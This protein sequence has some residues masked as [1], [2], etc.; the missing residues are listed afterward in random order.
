M[1]ENKPSAH[2]E[3]ARI[4]QPYNVEV[5]KGGCESCGHGVLYVV[6]GP[7]G[8]AG[9]VSYED[10]EAAQDECASKNEGY[11]KGIAAALESA[12]KREATQNFATLPDG[13]TAEGLKKMAEIIGER[14]YHVRFGQMVYR[15]SDWVAAHSGERD[16]EIAQLKAQIDSLTEERNEVIC[17]RESLKLDRDSARESLEISRKAYD[18]LVRASA[19]MARACGLE[20]SEQIVGTQTAVGAI[21]MIQSEYLSLRGSYRQAVTERDSLA[22]RN[23]NIRM[24]LRWCC[25]NEGECLADHPTYLKHARAALSQGSG[26]QPQ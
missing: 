8:I 2:A 9:S 6:V 5:E 7:D 13:M 14:G 4:A 3:A 20:N 11:E 22:E 23:Q 12:S 16:A 1:A 24:W 10:E 25:A 21:R 15:W 26:E 19:E 17:Q 18:S